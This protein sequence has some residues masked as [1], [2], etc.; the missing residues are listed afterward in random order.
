MPED[1]PASNTVPGV[2]VCHNCYGNEV[3]RQ[4]TL[5]EEPYRLNSTGSV[6][7]AA[8][9]YY[10]AL[11]QEKRQNKA[12]KDEFAHRQRIKNSVLNAKVGLPNT[13]SI[14]G[15]NVRFEHSNGDT[16]AHATFDNGK[17]F[18]GLTD[19]ARLNHG[20]GNV[21]LNYNSSNGPVPKYLENHVLNH[22]QKHWDSISK[23]ESGRPQ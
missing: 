9:S 23:D 15:W 7:D 17:Q 22:L 10:P 14:K 20:T 4:T 2:K 8:N 18:K 21:E 6:E 19:F 11:N 12:D 3:S 1:S 5:E 13:T 16:V